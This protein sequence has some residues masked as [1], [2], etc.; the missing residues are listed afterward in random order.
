MALSTSTMRGLIRYLP[1]TRRGGAAVPRLVIHP[2]DTTPVYEPFYI[3]PTEVPSGTL[4]EGA[5]WFDDDNHTLAFFDG[6]DNVEVVK[7]TSTGDL[8]VSDDL[9]VGDDLN[10]TSTG[11]ILTMGPAATN[12]ITLTQSADTLTLGSGDTFVADDIT[13]NDDLIVGDD[14]TMN[15]TGAI[16]QMGPTATN[17][18]TLTQSADTLTLGSGDTFVADDITVNDDLIVGDDLTL[19][20]TGA[21]LQLGPTATNPAIITHS[22][23]TLTLASGDTLAITTADKLTVGGNIVPQT[24]EISIPILLH[25]TA[26]EYML[27][28]A[29]AA[30]QVTNISM[31]PSILQGGAL[32][33]TIV[34]AADTATPV[35]TT[36]PMHTADALD[37]NAGAYTKQTPTLTVTTADLQLAAGDHIGIDFSAALTVGKADVAITLKRI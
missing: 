26:T 35:K 25:A 19:N 12:P 13:V 34:K 20:S 32:T 14:L 5:I 7:T 16:L 28:T 29:P 27:W 9:N 31:T 36:T 17:P 37:F 2:D 24:L 6:T 23:D 15:S 18:I 30:Y 11:A 10:M 21:I 4:A 33:G 1:G 22:A 3:R 8:T